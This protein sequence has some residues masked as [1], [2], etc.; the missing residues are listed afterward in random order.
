MHL[1]RA[2]SLN[3][4]AHV[5]HTQDIEACSAIVIALHT[6]DIL[7]IYNLFICIF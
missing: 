7:L 4:Y 6:H 1:M 5:H 2:L 3:L